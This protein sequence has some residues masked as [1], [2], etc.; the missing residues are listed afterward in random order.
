MT[1][2]EREKKKEIFLKIA[3]LVNLA[4]GLAQV[5]NDE[6]TMFLANTLQLVLVAGSDVNDSRKFSE[7]CLNYINE[8][9]MES[10]ELEVKE[11]LLENVP[12]GNN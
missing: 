9:L 10:G 5:I 11:H 7:H 3:N 1:N 2:A 8:K 6:Q 12:L 4:N